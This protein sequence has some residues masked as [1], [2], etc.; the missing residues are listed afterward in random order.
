MEVPIKNM[1]CDGCIKTATTF[2]LKNEWGIGQERRIKAYWKLKFLHRWMIK[3]IRCMRTLRHEIRHELK[4][5]PSLLKGFPYNIIIQL[6][7]V[8]ISAIHHHRS[9]QWVVGLNDHNGAYQ[10]ND[11][12]LQIKNNV[13]ALIFL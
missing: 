6:P 4:K 8:G 7:V 3:I 1:V 11:A 13:V 10:S 2:K 12:L 5:N 9:C